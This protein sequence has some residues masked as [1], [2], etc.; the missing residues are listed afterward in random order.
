MKG[1]REPFDELRAFF[2]LSSVSVSPLPSGFDGHSLYEGSHNQCV[3]CVRVHLCRIADCPEGRQMEMQGWPSAHMQLGSGRLPWILK[4][5]ALSSSL[6]AF[7]ERYVFHHRQSERV[8]F[9][10]C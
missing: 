6:E 7:E 8:S 9:I 1:K 5:S 4:V 2:L 10:L 3:M